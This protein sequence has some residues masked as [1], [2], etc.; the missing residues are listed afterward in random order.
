[1]GII[2]QYVLAPIFEFGLL[3]QT[4]FNAVFLG[5][6]VAV[7]YSVIQSALGRYAEI[8]TISEAVYMQVR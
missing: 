3:T 4:L 5:T 8:P 1:V 7:G 6:I 2:W